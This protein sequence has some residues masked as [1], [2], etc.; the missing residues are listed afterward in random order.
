MPMTAETVQGS[1]YDMGLQHGRAFRHVITGNVHAFALRHDFQGT[2]EE[3]DQA[4]EPERRGDETFAPWVFEELKGIAEGS[5][6]PLPLITRMHLRVWNR[7]PRKEL[8]PCGG[9]CTGIGLV[10]AECGAIVGGTLDDPRQSEVLI[11]R[12]PR[13]GIPHVQLT[14]A[15]VGWGHNGVNAAGLCIAES[16]L[17]SCTPALRYDDSKPRLRGS[18]GGRIL[19]EQCAD[20]PQ[21]VALL[22]RMQPTDSLV[23]GDAQG[24]LIACQSQ[25]GF[26]QA[27][28]TPQETQAFLF[29]TNHIHMPELVAKVLAGGCV[30][31]VTEY[32]MTRFAV[33][34]RAR[35]TMPRALETMRRLLQSHDGYPHS[36][37][38]DG[39]VMACYALPQRK[40]GVLFLADSP[41][42][43]NE[44]IEHHVAV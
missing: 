36:I 29:N 37:C 26:C 11:R 43:R 19:L 35:A 21:A 2:D 39:T 14:W 32:S 12:V 28:Q 17:G 23:I 10:A 8:K 3:L 18:M 44:F 22:K 30:P 42:C 41:P 38:N 5:G 31:K 33:L 1:H 4:L 16:S 27:F 15:G 6:V 40:P 20:V 13:D 34:E 25:G 9:G 7:V 24:N